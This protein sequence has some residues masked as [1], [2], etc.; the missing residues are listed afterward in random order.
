MDDLNTIQDST[1]AEVKPIE[2]IGDFDAASPKLD[3]T[4]P[5]PQPAQSAPTSGFVMSDAEA[6]PKAQSTT[7]T[8]QMIPVEQ[9]SANPY[10][11]RKVFD[12]VK[13]AELA[14]SIRFQGII[15][16][17]V[18]VKTSDGYEILVGERRYRASLLAGLKTV[19]AIVR[20]ELSDRAKLELALIENLQR[21][22]LN[23]M[24]EARAYSRLVEEFGMT[25]EQ[26]AQKV[27]KSRPAVANV[28][29]LLNLP[30]Q[31][32]RAVIENKLTE[33]HARALLPLENEI[34]KQMEVFEWIVRDQVTVREAEN[35]VRE[36]KNLP[37]KPYVRST[38]AI[39][40]DPELKQIE[41]RLREKL[42]TKVRLQKQGNTGKI[43]IE[44]YSQEELREI[45]DRLSHAAQTEQGFTV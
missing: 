27:G 42:G 17:L 28:L 29:R 37:L 18:L 10:Q 32:Q 19:P 44:F 33:G 11:P 22:D 5:A 40:P 14:E 7:G 25:Q 31:I 15:Q 35:R 6:E 20:G 34:E 2:D 30:A 36:L 1:G 38:K 12:P 4:P 21:E 39:N 13:L 8:V 43:L 23:P 24:E 41:D 45:I 26:I 16:P 9:I 3:N